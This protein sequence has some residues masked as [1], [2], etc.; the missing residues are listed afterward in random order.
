MSNTLDQTASAF[1]TIIFGINTGIASIVLNRPDQLNVYNIKMRDELWQVVSAIKDDTEVKVAL[2]SGA[3]DRAF[4][5]GADLTE[6]LSAPPPVAARKA[7]FDRDLWSLILS[8]PQPTIASL[9]GY[10]LGSGL[11][12]ALCCDLRIAA[13]NSRFGLPETVLGIIP[14]AGGSQTLPRAVGQAKALDMLLTGRWLDAGEAHKFHLVN[15]VVE[16]EQLKDQTLK[17]CNSII[18]SDSKLVRTIKRLVNEG[19][20]MDMSSAI[21]LETRMLRY[22][23]SAS[24]S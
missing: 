16:H 21:D 20:E 9:H 7:R 4:C 3:G 5:A 2:F 10:V 23:F 6:F 11:E 14:A 1:E 18:I 12:L 17:L 8:L 24:A 22:L 19:G 13:D 15:M